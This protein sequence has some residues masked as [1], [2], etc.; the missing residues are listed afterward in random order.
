MAASLS[1]VLVAPISININGNVLELPVLT[2]GD[3]SLLL[4]QVERWLK[5]DTNALVT[6]LTKDQT[7]PMARVLEL[8]ASLTRRANWGDVYDWIL[9]PEGTK[10]ILEASA[11]KAGVILPPDIYSP[12]DFKEAVFSIAGLTGV[13]FEKKEEP[14]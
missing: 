12:V 13:K 4:P 5:E 6:N 11:K 3:Y 7:V 14:K 2:L 8:K 9:T 10:A 1:T